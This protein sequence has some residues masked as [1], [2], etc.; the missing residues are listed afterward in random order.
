MR[1]TRLYSAVMAAVLALPLALT[2]SACSDD[3]DGEGEGFATLQD[4]YVDHH[5]EEGLGVQEALVV[6]CLDHPIAG[7]HPS[8]GNTVDDCIAHVDAN[9]DTSVTTDDIDAAC[10]T[11]VDEL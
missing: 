9:I 5:E 6:C 4:C 10:E 3:D 7:V 2:V 1:T 8:C 11:Y